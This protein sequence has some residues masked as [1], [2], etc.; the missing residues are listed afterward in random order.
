LKRRH[1][2]EPLDAPVVPRGPGPRG[3]VESESS[4]V[5]VAIIGSR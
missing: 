4:L 2:F 3:A 1:R 5:T